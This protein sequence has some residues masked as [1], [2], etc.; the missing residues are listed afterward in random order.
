MKVLKAIKAFLNF[1][2]AVLDVAMAAIAMKKLRDENALG[3][4]LKK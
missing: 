2:V 4:H 3:E 1:T